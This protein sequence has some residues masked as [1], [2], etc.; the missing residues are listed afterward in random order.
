MVTSG[1]LISNQH[2]NKLAQTGI[3]FAIPFFS[4]HCQ[5]KFYRSLKMH[6]VLMCDA[7]AIYTILNIRFGSNPTNVSGY[8]STENKC[9]RQT[10]HTCNS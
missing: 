2:S 3:F 6:R 9:L 7:A 10:R 5:Y 4:L 1:W 8:S